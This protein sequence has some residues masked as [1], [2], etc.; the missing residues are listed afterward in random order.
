MEYNLYNTKYDVVYDKIKP[1]IT[2]NFLSDK[3]IKEII[4]DKDLIK[5][6][7]LGAID[8]HGLSKDI[9]D[10]ATSQLLINGKSSKYSWLQERIFNHIKNIID[11]SD[12]PAIEV[13]SVNQI[14][15]LK[16]TGGGKYLWHSDIEFSTNTSHMQR[17]F[18]A[19]IVLN[20]RDVDFTGGHLKLKNFY[21]MEDPADKNYLR[22][23]S[24]VVFPSYM[25]H[26]VTPVTSGTRYSIVAW[27][28]GPY[29][30]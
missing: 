7:E 1:S 30:R 9:R 11:D 13:H 17:K 19:V 15:L 5:A 8:G 16:Y 2:H 20:E 26:I 21:N 14:E 6:R 25:S 18:S 3:E 24:I 27:C 4:N 12:F 29:W 10:V 22:P 28:V 23:G